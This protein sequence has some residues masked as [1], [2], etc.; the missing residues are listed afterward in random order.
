M[1]EQGDASAQY[2]L[3]YNYYAVEG[4]PQDYKEALRWFRAGAEQGDAGAQLSL[5]LMYAN[6]EGTPQD[7][8]LAHMWW[9]LAAAA[10][11]QTAKTNRDIVAGEMTPADIS[12]AQQMASDWMKAHP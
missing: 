11:N 5:G 8:K 4:T 7:N 12:D 2:T 9:N 3:G 6:G 1:A 10:G